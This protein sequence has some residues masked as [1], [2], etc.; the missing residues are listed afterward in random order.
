MDVKPIVD[1]FSGPFRVRGGAKTS[2]WGKVGSSSRIASIVPSTDETARL[3]EYWLGAHESLPAHV[4]FEDGSVKALDSFFRDHAVRVLGESV[5]RRYQNELPF[6]LKVLSINPEHG[7][8]IQAHPDLELARRLHGQAPSRYPDPRHKPEIGLPLTPV[9]LLYGFKARERL[10]AMLDLFPELRAIVHE[11]E[12]DQGPEVFRSAFTKLFALGL[13]GVQAVVTAIAS[14]IKRDGA[15]CPEAEVFSRLHLQYGDFD[16]GL[17]ALFLMNLVSIQPGEGI[18]IPANLPHAYLDGD[19]VE[20]MACSDNVVRAGLTP[21]VKD[22]ATLIEMVTYSSIAPVPIVPVKDEEGF[23]VFTTPAEE[24]E[25]GYVA[26]G[27]GSYCISTDLGARVL[28]SLGEK[29]VVRSLATGRLVELSDGEAA[30]LPIQSGNFEVICQ[31]SSV[32]RT[33]VAGIPNAG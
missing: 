12:F 3:A 11:D 18:F 2:S 19:L 27:S 15:R 16:E 4:L 23:L 10:R 7:L 24:F 17:L 28:M 6:L 25:V 32:Y 8:S 5:A 21:K 30:L 31:N 33:G 22:I 1:I 13:D 9:T 26:Q 20:C 29:S 14:R